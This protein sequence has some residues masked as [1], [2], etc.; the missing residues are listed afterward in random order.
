M[1]M[2]NSYM[3]AQL[4]PINMACATLRTPVGEKEA[5]RVDHAPVSPV[6]GCRFTYGRR[7]LLISGDTPQ[8]DNIRRFAEGIELLIHKAFSPEVIGMMEDTAKSLGNEIFYCHV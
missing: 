5:S 6:V 8:S 3:L 1:V 7:I 2:A 4:M